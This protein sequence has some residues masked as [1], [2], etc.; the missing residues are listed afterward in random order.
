MENAN[1]KSKKLLEPLFKMV[2]DPE[3][4]GQIVEPKDWKG[5]HNTSS[6]KVISVRDVKGLLQAM[7]ELGYSSN[8]ECFVTD[9]NFGTIR[10]AGE[11][12]VYLISRG[13]VRETSES[14]NSGED[15]HDAEKALQI[16]TNSHIKKKEVV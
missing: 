3:N 2:P 7:E 10:K 16:P 9:E 1:E 14:L 11:R 6:S 5:V 12:Q 4:E 13:E 15:V 8:I